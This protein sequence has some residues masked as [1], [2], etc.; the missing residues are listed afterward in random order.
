MNDLITVYS[1]TQIE[2][3][4]VRHLLEAEGINTLLQSQHGLGFVI[5]AGNMLESYYISVSEKD[6]ERAQELVE[7]YF[8]K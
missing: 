8:S 3:E 2:A 6:V 5:R 4:L 1:G 7:A